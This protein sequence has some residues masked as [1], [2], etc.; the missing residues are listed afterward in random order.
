[1]APSSIVS[2][3]RFIAV[4]DR[5]KNKYSKIGCNDI[6][7]RAELIGHIPAVAPHAYLFTLYN[8]LD[9]GMI[10][11]IQIA[12][13]RTIPTDLRQ[14][15]GICNGANYFVNQMAM[16]G[17]RE[18]YARTGSES[19]QP[20]CLV[21]ANTDERPR[22]LPDEYIVIGYYQYDG[23]LLCL[24]A[25]SGAVVRYDAEALQLM[26]SW[27]GLWIML[28]M[29]LERLD[30]MYDEQGCIMFDGMDTTPQKGKRR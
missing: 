26:N 23:S 6:E 20:Y 24:S 11:P 21:S 4:A 17:R 9:S 13:G 8:K 29:E 27:V 18:S 14:Y 28:S 2:K 5:L 30:S 22:L 15:L 10:A 3:N 12:M 7:G 1:M 25:V 16:M 19:Y